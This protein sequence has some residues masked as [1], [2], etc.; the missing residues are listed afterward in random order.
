MAPRLYLRNGLRSHGAIADLC[1]PGPSDWR[2]GGGRLFGARKLAPHRLPLPA[3]P[4]L[5]AEFVHRY[6]AGASNV[7]IQEPRPHNKAR[8]RRGLSA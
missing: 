5:H 2:A 4:Q 1:S 6:G 8:W 7:I 3:R